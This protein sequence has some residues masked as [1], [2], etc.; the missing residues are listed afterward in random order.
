MKNPLS[1]QPI[2]ICV[3]TLDAHLASAMDH[4][5]EDD[6]MQ[7]LGGLRLE[8]ALSAAEF[9]ADAAKLQALAWKILPRRA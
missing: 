2:R 6:Y 7:E 8:S 9:A 3:I 4:G 1:H 5:A